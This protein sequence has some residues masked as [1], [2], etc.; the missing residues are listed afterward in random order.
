MRS[1]SWLVVKGHAHRKLTGRWVLLAVTFN[2][3][4]GHREVTEKY[5]SV[6]KWSKYVSL[7]NVKLVKASLQENGTKMR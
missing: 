7:S 5:R 4:G 2:K 3:I 1:K 6:V